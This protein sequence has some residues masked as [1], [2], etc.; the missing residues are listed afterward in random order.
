MDAA[1]GAARL[2]VHVGRD[3]PDRQNF[4]LAASPEAGL[5]FPDAAARFETW[6]ADQ[7]PE[8]PCAAVLRDRLE[9]AETAAPPVRE[10]GG[11]SAPASAD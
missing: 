6:P 1:F 2:Y 11:R 9:E 8:L 7:W 3:F 4:L 10:R 5:R